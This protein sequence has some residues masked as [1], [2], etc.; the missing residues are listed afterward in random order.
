MD[1]IWSS[2]PNFKNQLV[3]GFFDID[4]YFT[5]LYEEKKLYLSKTYKDD[6][7]EKMLNDFQNHLDRLRNFCD[8][9]F[10]YLFTIF[11]EDLANDKNKS[12]IK[13]VLYGPNNHYTPEEELFLNAA[14]NNFY[15]NV[16]SKGYPCNMREEKITENDFMEG[17]C[18]TC[19]KVI[20]ITLK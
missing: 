13:I 8:G 19:Y 1:N 18:T 15:A 11:K 9:K 12:I 14:I 17:T 16:V 2:I 3:T 4:I 5:K 7:A 20:E 6:I 10:N